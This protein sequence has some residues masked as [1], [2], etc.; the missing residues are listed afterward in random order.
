M[1][2]ELIIFSLGSNIGNR[3]EFL[4]NGLMSLTKVLGECQACSSIYETPPLGFEADNFFLNI[5]AS[6]YSS[7]QPQEVIHLIHAIETDQGRKKT[8]GYDKYESRTLDIDIIYFG[9]YVI[10]EEN[11]NIP[12]LRRLDRKF[13]LQPIA[14]IHPSFMDPLKNKTVAA[15]NSRAKDDSLIKKLGEIQY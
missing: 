7:L 4:R 3:E 9:Q 11:L 14:E 2:K 6:F 8:I 1:D 15:L 5:A 12:H 13:V 10:D